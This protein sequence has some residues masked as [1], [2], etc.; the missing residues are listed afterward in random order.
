M[1]QSPSPIVALGWLTASYILIKLIHLVGIYILP[2]RLHRF[3]HVAP[4]GD[5]P[6]ALVT[7]A[8]DGI[9][10]AFA[11][12]LATQG[13]NVVLH[14]R[15]PAKL[16]SVK[17][18]LQKKHPSRSFRILVADASKVACTNCIPSEQHHQNSEALDFKAIGAELEG[19]HL[20]VLI[21]NAGGMST[22]PTYRLLMDSSEERI[23]RN[24]SL[25]AIFPLHMMRQFLPTLCRNGPS[26]IIN[27][28][29]L[30]D[31]GFPLLSSYGSSKQ[32]LMT[33]TRSV[34]L[35]MPLGHGPGL[36]QVELLGVRVGR[37]TGVAAYKEE[38]SLF[39][40][41]AQDMARAALSRAGYGH[42]CV[43]GYWSHALQTVGFTVLPKWLEGRV[44]QGVMRNERAVELSKKSD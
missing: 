40:P 13:F 25:N 17:D 28:S 6:W 21:N 12:E 35:E 24:V 31:T 26:L 29:S 27:I 10:A 23:T 20:T 36:D 41:S 19:L 2:S 4:N 14:G 22:S 7:G 34:A 38:P 3:A 32:F 15:N 18:G 37:V 33:L 1:P 8:S 16:N 11:Q 44:L 5:S 9:G 39:T 42:G 43:I 30:A